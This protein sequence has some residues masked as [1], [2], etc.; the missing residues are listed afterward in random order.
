MT[1]QNQKFSEGLET[2]S[3]IGRRPLPNLPHLQRNNPPRIIPLSFPPPPQA[4]LH[5]R[6]TNKQANHRTTRHWRASK[7]CHCLQRH[8]EQDMERADCASRCHW[9]RQALSFP[10]FCQ[11]HC[12]R[13]VL[14]NPTLT[15]SQRKIT[16]FFD[17]IEKFRKTRLC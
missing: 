4:L 9:H 13:R 3:S 17:I 1:L 16:W 6:F 2:K 8:Y 7:V 5:L 15:N 12:Q 14:R 10:R 11:T